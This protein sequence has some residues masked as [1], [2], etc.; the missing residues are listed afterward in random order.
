MQRSTS[1]KFL[2]EQVHVSLRCTSCWLGL[3]CT[4]ALVIL[5]FCGELNLGVCVVVHHV[6]L[7]WRYEPGLW[8]CVKCMPLTLLP[9][10]SQ[11]LLP[12]RSDS[13][14][15]LQSLTYPLHTLYAHTHDT[16]RAPLALGTLS[17]RFKSRGTE[18]SCNSKTHELLACTR[19]C[20]VWVS[21]PHD[22]Y[23]TPFIHDLYLTHSALLL[24]PSSISPTASLY[25]AHDS[26]FRA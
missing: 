19:V 11:P 4:H 17:C 22:L 9:A 25:S 23:L 3:G 2:A 13:C 20:G 7:G 26:S 21:A 8:R 24:R 6:R 5:D 10:Y 12:N 14:H 16:S 15:L 18:R 1:D